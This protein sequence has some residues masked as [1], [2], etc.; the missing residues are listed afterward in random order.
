MAVSLQSQKCKKKTTI[1]LECFETSYFKEETFA[2][3]T[4][5]RLKNRN[6]LLRT[7]LYDIFRDNKLL[8]MTKILSFFFNI[9]LFEIFL[10]LLILRRK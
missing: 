10:F 8:R 9:I 1:V 6:K 5:T 4:F 3:L 7:I 2:K